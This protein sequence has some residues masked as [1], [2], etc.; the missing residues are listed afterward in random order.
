MCTR[1]WLANAVTHVISSSGRRECLRRGQSTTKGSRLHP[2]GTMNICTKIHEKPSNSSWDLSV[3]T[4]DRPHLHDSH[5]AETSLWP[6]SEKTTS[7]VLQMSRNR[8]WEILKLPGITCEYLY[9]ITSF[10]ST[11]VAIKSTIQ[12]CNVIKLYVTNTYADCNEPKE[13]KTVSISLDNT[14]QFSLIAFVHTHL[15]FTVALKEMQEMHG[16]CFPQSSP[17]NMTQ[18]MFLTS[19]QQVSGFAIKIQSWLELKCAFG[20]KWPDSEMLWKCEL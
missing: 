8:S 9:I 7:G 11:A 17:L 20:H 10:G 4:S 6:L 5:A 12:S 16:V 13:A 15:L 3:W 14:Q 19:V 2:L 18:W 1:T